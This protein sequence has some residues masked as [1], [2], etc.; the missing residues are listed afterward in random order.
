M[1]LTDQARRCASAAPAQVVLVESRG[2]RRRSDTRNPV[3]GLPKLPVSASKLRDRTHTL[4]PLGCR[5]KPWPSQSNDGPDPYRR[6][7]SSISAAGTPVIRSPHS[8]VQ[9]AAAARP[10]PSRRV[11]RGARDRQSSRRIRAAGQKPAPHRSR[12]RREC[13]S[14]AAAVGVRMGSTT[15][16]LPGASGSQWSCAW[17]ADADGFAPQTRMQRASARCAG[18]SR[19]GRC[20]RYSSATCPALLQTVSGST[21]VAP[22]PVEE[23]QRKAIADQRECPGVV[24]VEDRLASARPPSARQSLRA[25]LPRRPPR[26]ARSLRAAAP[27]RMKQ[28]RFWVAQ[29]A[30]IGERAFAAQPPAADRMRRVATDMTDPSTAL[31]HLDAAGV[32]AVARAG[33]EDNFV[34]CFDS[35]VYDHAATARTQRQLSYWRGCSGRALLSR[36]PASAPAGMKSIVTHGSPPTTQASWPGPTT[37]ASPGPRSSSRPSSMRT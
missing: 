19:P 36:S 8:G 6:A 15:I 13:R 5:C 17:G 2:S 31:D 24:G 21:S 22:D 7:A 4:P 33:C 20:R 26:T 35:S 9:S 12:E 27:Q 10:R 18:Q 3:P 16:T 32:V 11:S 14:A 34:H 30:V 23:A 29:D 28:T 25:P 1:W 37:W